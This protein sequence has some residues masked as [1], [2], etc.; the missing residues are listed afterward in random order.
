MDANL[1]EAKQMVMP[2]KHR[3]RTIKVFFNNC[4]AIIIYCADCGIQ[5]SKYFENLDYEECP[6]GV[7]DS[8]EV[9]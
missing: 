9:S 1:L 8:A 2:H 6:I 3:P 7:T 5:I 4:Y